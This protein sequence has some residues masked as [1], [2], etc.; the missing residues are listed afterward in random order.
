[1]MHFGAFNIANHALGVKLRAMDSGRS[2]VADPVAA[3][4]CGDDLPEWADDDE[5]WPEPSDSDQ[6]Y[7]AVL[8]F[9]ATTRSADSQLAPL[10]A[11]QEWAKSDQ[12]G[13]DAAGDAAAE[14]QTVACLTDALFEA[15]DNDGDSAL[16]TAEMRALARARLVAAVDKVEARGASDAWVRRARRSLEGRWGDDLVS[17]A[18]EAMLLRYDENKC[19]ASGHTVWPGGCRG[20]VELLPCPCCWFLCARA[21]VRACV[22]ACLCVCARGVPRLVCSG[23]ASCNARR[24]RLLLQWKSSS[25]RTCE[26]GTVCASVCR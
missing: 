4:D 21:C 19:V 2:D 13:S 17:S 9:A 25:T 22:R 20:A 10:E 12:D 1:M 8:Q 5:R 24:W 6:L 16:N 18:V 11:H 26:F 23:T 15:F 3:G 14:D 7:N